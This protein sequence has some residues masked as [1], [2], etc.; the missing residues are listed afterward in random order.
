MTPPDRPLWKRPLLWAWAF[1][2]F[3]NSAFATTTLAVVFNVYFAKSV[4][5]PEGIRFLG[6]VLSG[7][8]LWSFTVSVSMFVMV[9]LAPLLGAVADLSGKR[10][11]FLR[12]F[13][14]LGVLS[15]VGLF[16]VT[17]GR[18]ALAV[19]L[20]SLAN[21]GFAGGNAF[22]NAYLPDLGPRQSLGA[23]SGF[24]WAVGY[25]GGG[26]CLALD[27]ALIQRPAWFGL[28]TDQFLPVRA[29]LLSV[30]LWWGLFGFPIFLFA[31]AETPGEG[32]SARAWA[33]LGWSRLLDTA[34]HLARY[35][36]LMIFVLAYALYNDGIET[37][38]LT[39]SV[40]GAELLGLS[41]GELIQCFLM[42][43]GVAF[44]GSLL[45]GALADRWRH[46]TVILI[47]L[48]VY[49]GVILW[50]ARMTSRGEFWVLGVVL[51]LVLGGSQAASRSL[52]GL[53]T[54]PERS[55]EFF[56]FFGVV[57]KLTAVLG[58]LVFGLAAQAG[59]VRRGVLSLLVFFILGGTVLVFVKEPGTP[60]PAP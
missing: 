55:G 48:A 29:S 49:T 42:I 21:M 36:N 6:A 23:I 47:T 60:P 17:P 52:M 44:L 53:L 39:A 57:G 15:S 37:V 27:L 16:W 8:A 25:I 13:W 2:D 22:Y 19:I 30:G 58:P 50:G 43:Q 18:V 7:P 59:G 12:F 35:R 3:A 1:Y 31:P 45:F 38:I 14:A 41:S 46:K 28:S 10:K 32:R 51:G 40:V 34:R 24:G 33:R 4:V 54:P 11:S 20:F 56:G 26:L 5:P 9:L